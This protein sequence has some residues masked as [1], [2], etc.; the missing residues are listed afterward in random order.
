[1]LRPNFLLG[2]FED[3]ENVPIRGGEQSDIILGELRSDCSPIVGVDGKGSCCCCCC[4]YWLF[5]G[6]VVGKMSP[7]YLENCFSCVLVN[8]REGVID[9]GNG[10]NP[11]ISI[12]DVVS[13]LICLFVVCLF[14]SCCYPEE[15][16]RE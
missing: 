4:W 13:S 8:G 1:M 15:E 10:Y 6:F 3:E 5:R 2:I 16:V 12:G 7:R 14:V 9:S 11:A